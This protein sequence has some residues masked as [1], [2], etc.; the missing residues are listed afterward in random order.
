MSTGRFTPSAR[1]NTLT[2]LMDSFPSHQWFRLTAIE[3]H[4]HVTIDTYHLPHNVDERWPSYSLWKM[5][6][7]HLGAHTRGDAGDMEKLYVLGGKQRKALIKDP[8]KE[9]HWY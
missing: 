6:T 5:F 3:I 4:L 7:P 9:W 1:F 8:S 2:V